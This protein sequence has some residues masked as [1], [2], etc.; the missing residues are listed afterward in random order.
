M[1]YWLMILVGLLSMLWG[2][3]TW[4]VDWQNYE[5]DPELTEY[6][7]KKSELVRQSL[8]DGPYKLRSMFHGAAFQINAWPMLL[9]KRVTWAPVVLVLGVTLFIGGILLA[10]M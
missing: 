9:R 3:W 5:D 10:A 1:V 8:E 2:G 7:N 6:V 4:A